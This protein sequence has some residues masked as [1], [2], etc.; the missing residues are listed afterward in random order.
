MIARVYDSRGR[1]ID[2]KHFECEPS[3]NSL[4]VVLDW[5]SENYIGASEFGPCYE[6]VVEDSFG[7]VVADFH[8]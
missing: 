8:T 5:F 1:T 7:E 6:C 3:V 2:E 4:A